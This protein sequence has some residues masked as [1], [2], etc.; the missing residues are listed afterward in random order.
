MAYFATPRRGQLWTESRNIDSVNHRLVRWFV[1]VDVA[2]DQVVTVDVDHDGWNWRPGRDW[3]SVAAPTE[4][5]P[6]T[7][8]YRYITAQALRHKNFVQLADPQW[9]DCVLPDP[10]PRQDALFDLHHWAER[11]LDHGESR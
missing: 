11:V 4:P 8:P 6:V 10:P 3:G 2:D 7:G 1:V 9:V 5:T